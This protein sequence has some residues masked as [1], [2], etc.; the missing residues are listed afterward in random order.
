MG[1]T[2]L[3]LWNIYFSTAG[4]NDATVYDKASM[5]QSWNKFCFQGG[6]IEV[7]TSTWSRHHYV[8]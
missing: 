1:E 4:Y 6:M 3:A 8:G 5:M 7:R 2:A